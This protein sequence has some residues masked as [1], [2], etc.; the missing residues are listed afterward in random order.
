MTLIRSWAL[1]TGFL[2][3]LAACGGGTV[4]PGGDGGDV[5]Q[6]GDSPVSYDGPGPSSDGGDA[7]PG[8]ACPTTPPTDGTACSRPSLQCSYGTD[9]DFHCRRVATC[10]PDTGHWTVQDPEGC[11]LD[12]GAPMCPATAPMTTDSCTSN[13]QLCA[14]DNGMRCTCADC[15]PGGPVCMSGP[16]RWFCDAPSDANCPRSM[17]NLGDPCSVENTQCDYG[18]CIGNGWAVTCQGGVW[19]QDQMV[20]CAA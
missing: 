20:A 14:Y 11:M 9:P 18:M 6:M 3:A 5:M 7:N 2:L 10:A 12:A 8:P 15:P 16:L 1:G 4:T 19:V 17:P 13:R